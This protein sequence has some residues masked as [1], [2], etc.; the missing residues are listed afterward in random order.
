MDSVDNVTTKEC[1][2]IVDMISGKVKAPW[3]DP[4]TAPS[5]M[6]P[7]GIFKKAVLALLARDPSKRMSLR[8]F[9]EECSRALV[10]TG[11]E[12]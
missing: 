11:S 6:K 9:K 10:R 7:L 1:V 3:E 4:E 5:L 12:M 2:Q 8:D